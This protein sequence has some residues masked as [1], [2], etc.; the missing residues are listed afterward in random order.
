LPD[1]ATVPGSLK[2]LMGNL[3]GLEGYPGTTSYPIST[4]TIQDFTVEPQNFL[5]NITDAVSMTDY[6]IY[7]G[8]YYV[9]INAR[10]G[11]IVESGADEDRMASWL[12]G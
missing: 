3:S 1:D 11:E 5:D 9:L 7:K 6:F 8:N 12:N 4:I 2:F 10:T